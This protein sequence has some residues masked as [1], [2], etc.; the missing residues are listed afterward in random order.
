[1]NSRLTET[2]FARTRLALL[3]ARVGQGI[4]LRELMGYDVVYNETNDDMM[5]F[6]LGGP[7]ATHSGASTG[8]HAS[9]TSPP[10][11]F[12]MEF[13]NQPTGMHEMQKRAHD[14][15]CGC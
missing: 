15:T 1:M 10:S 7:A 14:F 4:V 6:Q 5:F 3:P 2:S 13:S 8:L 9:F 11:V 12:L